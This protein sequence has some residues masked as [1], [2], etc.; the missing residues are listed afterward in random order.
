MSDPDKMLKEGTTLE[1]YA[2]GAV[3]HAPLQEKKDATLSAQRSDSSQSRQ[4]ATPHHTP[5]PPTP[6][7]HTK[8]SDSLLRHQ[9]VWTFLYQQLS[10]H[11][12]RTKEMQ[13]RVI[14]ART[15]ASCQGK[16]PPT[17]EPTS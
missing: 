8:H 10:A 17:S 9:H 7:E 11:K 4:Q 5:P 13:A 12:Q 2:P 3:Q 14:P 15:A 1:G 6:N 16:P